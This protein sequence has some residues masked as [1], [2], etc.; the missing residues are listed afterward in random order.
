MPW[1]PPN[2]RAERAEKNEPI[3]RGREQRLELCH[4]RLAEDGRTEHEANRAYQA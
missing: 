2:D 1:P 3:P 4:R